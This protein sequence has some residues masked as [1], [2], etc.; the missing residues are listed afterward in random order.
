MNMKKAPHFDKQATQADA[1]NDWFILV[2]TG[3]NG[4][5]YRNKEAGKGEHWQL[6]RQSYGLAMDYQP[7]ILSSK[8]F[9]KIDRLR[10]APEAQRSLKIFQV[11][12]IPTMTIGKDGGGGID[13]LKTRILMN[14]AKN[15][16]H[17]S[18]IEWLDEGLTG[19]N[20][21]QLLTQIKEGKDTLAETL[22]IQAQAQTQAQTQAI[23]NLSEKPS[24]RELLEA[25]LCWYEYPLGVD[26]ITGIIYQFT[27]V[28]WEKLSNKMLGRLVLKFHEVHD[29]S[30][31]EKSITSL[32]NLIALK[33][34]ILPDSVGGLIGFSNGVL[35]KLTGEF[36]PHSKAN[37]LR[38][39]EDY[40]LDVTSTATPH[41]DDWLDY[42]AN[43]NELKRQAFLAGLYMV[44]T[45][46]YHWHYYLEAVGV[47]RAG[48]SIFG[49]IATILNGRENTTVLDIASFDKPES[50]S[51]IVGKTL[52]ISPDQP[53]Y[54][55]SADGLKSATGGDTLTVRNLYNNPS[56]YKPSIVF[57]YSTNHAISF[58]DRNGG[59]AGRRII[60]YFNR[61]IPA[62]KRDPFFLDKVKLEVYGIVHKL[63]AEFTDPE[64]ARR[65]LAE[66]QKQNDSAEVK[67]EG[68][69][70]VNFASNFR[71]DNGRKPLITWG[72]NRT[73]KNVQQALYKAYLFYCDC[74][75]LKPLNVS[76]FKHAFAD[77]LKESGETSEIR[78]AMRDG[79]PVLN[80]HWKN[81]TQSISRWENG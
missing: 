66:F 5:Y 31:T 39:V 33:A 9:D 1:F 14:V 21:F 71:V 2:G 75:N 53:P 76:T 46:R 36:S 12:E 65:I 52:A 54:I 81:F 47:A 60:Y 3:A 78:E 18:A 24:Q 59:H 62:D 67:R 61:T 6:I 50:L 41:F 23:A 73:K 38:G 11:G 77:A 57:M 16:P 72:S 17:I 7:V 27:G 48:K 45:N 70:L 20:L 34:E 68:N 10:L 58:T 15:N 64:Q 49:E 55:G 8:M 63:L 51:K 26:I 28:Y 37:Y 13:D 42:S 4:A 25:F 44:L 69:H 30:F 80:L 40:A 29:L 79:Y 35:N 19:T 32:V 74:A 22:Q 56:D 43:G